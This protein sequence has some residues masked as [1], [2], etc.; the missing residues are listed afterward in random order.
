MSKARWQ[1]SLKSRDCLV[2]FFA[3]FQRSQLRYASTFAFSQLGLMH[4][5]LALD[6][7]TCMNR[8]WNS[9]LIWRTMTGPKWTERVFRGSEN[10]W[11]GL[12]QFLSWNGASLIFATGVQVWFHLESEINRHLK[13]FQRT[14]FYLS[15]D[16]ILCEGDVF[17]TSIFTVCICR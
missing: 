14:L 16:R 1:H 11:G 6:S 15:V 2:E 12:K 17:Y 10:G 9:R 3:C 7:Q 4:F 8:L 13:M 5:F